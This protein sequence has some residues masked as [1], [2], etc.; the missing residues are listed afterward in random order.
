MVVPPTFVLTPDPL[1]VTEGKPVKMTCKAHGKPIPEVRWY[2]DDD[3]IT[4]DGEMKIQSKEISRKLEVESMLKTDKT[5]L[6]DES[7]NYRIIAE[8]VA[9]SAVHELSL[10]GTH[11]LASLSPIYSGLSRYSW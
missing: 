6:Q 5:L 4:G 9:G 11:I 10:I 1:E 2:K 3:L 7:Q 8:N